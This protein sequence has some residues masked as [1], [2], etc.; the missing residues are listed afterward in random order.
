MTNVKLTKEVVTKGNYEVINNANGTR[1]FLRCSKEGVVYLCDAHGNTKD[2]KIS[3]IKALQ[4]EGKLDIVDLNDVAMR[5][6]QEIADLRR[7]LEEQIRYNQELIE[8]KKARD[9]REAR[10]LRTVEYP[11]TLIDGMNEVRQKKTL[12]LQ[13]TEKVPKRMFNEVYHALKE[14]YP[15]TYYYAPKRAIVIGSV[16][17]QN[18]WKI[19][20]E[21]W[22]R[23][24]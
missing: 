17:E 11:V 20:E 7:R 1:A 19:R 23:Y 18:Y 16:T 5:E 14:L 12:E 3:D 24:C 21:V 6:K 4:K 13:F 9:L 22:T 2:V 15:G 10:Q 8:Q